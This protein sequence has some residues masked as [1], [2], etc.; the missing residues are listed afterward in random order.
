[1]D[2]N[3]QNHSPELDYERQVLQTK[4]RQLQNEL[5]LTQQEYNCANEKYLEIVNNLE[6]KVIEKSEQVFKSQL[7]LKQKKEEL[8]LMLDNTPALIFYKTYEL[9]YL[10]VN[11]KYLSLF[12]FSLSDVLLKKDPEI[13]NNKGFNIELDKK[14]IATKT[15]L[16]HKI[17][18]IE[19]DSGV[20]NLSVDRIPL[21]NSL[22]EVAGLLCF[23]IDITDLNKIEEENSL[24]LSQLR[25]AQKLD[26]LGTLASGI[27]HDF[28]NILA[29]IIGYTEMSLNIESDPDNQKKYL[30]EVLNAS[31]RA[32]DLIKQILTFSRKTETVFKPIDLI[33]IIDE[34]IKFLRPSIP[35][36][37]EIIFNK[38]SSNAIILGDQT[39]IHQVVMNLCT[40]AFQAIK[41][42]KGTIEVSI[43]KIHITEKDGLALSPGCYYKISVH[44]TGVGISN[45]MIEKIFDP[46]FTTKKHG[47]G[48]GL[49]L[50]VALGIINVH[51]GL[52][53]VSST[54]NMGTQFS[55]YLPKLDFES[56]KSKASE[57]HYLKGNGTIL[58]VDDEKPISSLYCDFLTG[59]GY[60]IVST[61][62]S[63]KAWQYFKEQP[64]TFDLVISDM[65]MPKL[66]GID[67][68]KKIR[69]INQEVPVFLSSGY[70]DEYNAEEIANLNIR[71]VIQ[72]PVE[73]HIL[74]QFIEEVLR[75]E[76]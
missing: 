19:T 60:N 38:Y 20:Y 30:S 48:T 54:E 26:S 70:G 1:M 58:V 76:K 46:Y 10:Q 73:L 57:S 65:T 22:G 75:K 23:A 40:N 15:A 3:K 25:Q 67:L 43:L 63:T 18:T 7:I 28:N 61:S 32:K 35:V 49:G 39:Q 71:R 36:S 8:Q 5:N 4:L 55:V 56:I 47:E 68:I 33:A 37:I 9:S 31:F 72:K 42:K 51:K 45:E 13:F 62:S 21:I 12:N 64:N 27:A 69:A 11:N 74:S 41:N 17:E 29:A 34:V 6:K 14:A 44:D 2:E 66:T 24:L 16:Y 52:I 53:Q 59:L 50:S